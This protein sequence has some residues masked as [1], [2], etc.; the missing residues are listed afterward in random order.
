LL[1]DN[2]SLRQRIERIEAGDALFAGSRAEARRERYLRSRLSDSSNMDIPV[3]DSG[4]GRE[5]RR[6]LREPEG[7][8]TQSTS[9]KKN[10]SGG[11]SVTGS[12]RADRGIRV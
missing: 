1:Y 4:A 9:K 10:G 6:R 12:S 5:K 2:E 7:S 11:G 3:E 8:A